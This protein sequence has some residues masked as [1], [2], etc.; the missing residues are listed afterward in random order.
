MHCHAD[1][2]LGKCTWTKCPQ[3]RDGEPYNSGRRCPYYKEIMKRNIHIK[4]DDGQTKLD[5]QIKVSTTHLAKQETI[6]VQSEIIR[7]VCSG[8]SDIS[9]TNFGIDNITINT[10]KR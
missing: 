2:D 5:I 10:I 8:L 4:A 1:R 7:R 6:R 9:Y 3:R